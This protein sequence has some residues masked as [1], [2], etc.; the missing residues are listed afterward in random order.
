[1][2]K[3][4]ATPLFKKKLLFFKKKVVFIPFLHYYIMVPI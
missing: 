1:M 2:K 3:K 4:I